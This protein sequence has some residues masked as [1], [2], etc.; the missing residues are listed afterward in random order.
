MIGTPEELLHFGR[1]P[2]EHERKL[3]LEKEGGTA[4]NKRKL[5]EIARKKAE[6]DIPKAPVTTSNMQDMIRRELQD[7]HQDQQQQQQQNSRK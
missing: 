4:I 3:W 7:H 5:I 6:H 2:T 1:T